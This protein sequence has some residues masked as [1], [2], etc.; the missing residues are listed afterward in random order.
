LDQTREILVVED[1][2][3][4]RRL[5]RMVLQREG[6]VVQEAADGV[7]AVLKLGISDYDVIVLDLMMPNLDGFAFISTLAERDAARLKRII[8]TS[9]ASP[10][11]IEGRMRATPFDT[12]PK[13]FD[14]KDLVSR[15]R[16]C[17]T[18][19]TE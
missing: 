2:R 14:L 3:A 9:A 13:P 10:S 12:L 19:Q 11:V 1:D 18:A 15:V 17:I 8:V 7:E 5:L 6:Y 4:I 16:A